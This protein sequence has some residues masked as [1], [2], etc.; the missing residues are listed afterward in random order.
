MSQPGEVREF[1][2]EHYL[3]EHAITA[4]FALVKEWKN[5]REGNVIFKGSARNFNVPMCKAAETSVVEVEEIIDVGSFAPEDIQV[6]NMYVDCVILGAKY[7]KRIKH[8]TIR[9]EEDRKDMSV[10]DPRARIIK[11]AA[12][13]FE[14]GMYGKY[15]LSLWDR[16][17][18]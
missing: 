11:Q 3:S 9:T 16:M 5:N 12:L 2:W 1:H 17:K 8:L 13:E 14:D 15:P 6:P 4:D 18:I 10:N 7:E